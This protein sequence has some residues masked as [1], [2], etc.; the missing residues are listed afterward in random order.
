M[1]PQHIGLG[2]QAQVIADSSMYCGLRTLPTV[3]SVARCGG[4]VAG[5]IQHSLHRS[6]WYT[7]QAPNS[8]DG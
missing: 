4:L 3:T 1:H 5:L 2:A 7:Q 6:N 8:D